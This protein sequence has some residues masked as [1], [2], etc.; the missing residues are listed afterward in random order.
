MLRIE[1][2]RSTIVAVAKPTRDS[3]E[4]G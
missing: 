3:W 4:E 1:Y 2:G